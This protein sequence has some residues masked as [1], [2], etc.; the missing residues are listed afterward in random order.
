[1]SS[2]ASRRSPHGHFDLFDHSR[3]HFMS[4]DFGF[5]SEKESYPSEIPSVSLFIVLPLLFDFC[6]GF[7]STTRNSSIWI[8]G[9]FGFMGIAENQMSLSSEFCVD[10]KYIPA[11]IYCQ[12]QRTTSNLKCLLGAKRWSV[13]KKPWGR[14]GTLCSQNPSTIHPQ[15]P[16]TPQKT[17]GS[18]FLYLFIYITNGLYLTHINAESQHKIMASFKYWQHFQEAMLTWNLFLGI[19]DQI[20]TW[21]VSLQQFSIWNIYWP[22]VSGHERPQLIEA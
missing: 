9:L 10:I 6:A 16:F 14:S 3:I 20:L 17:S 13:E 5:I 2:N 21:L 11:W 8:L 1:M 7:H 19:K 22:S 4:R 15:M 12:P 18:V